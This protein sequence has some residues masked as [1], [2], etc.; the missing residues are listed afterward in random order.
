MVTPSFYAT[1]LALVVLEAT[2]SCDN[3][4]V[5]AICVK[6]LPPK[7][8]KHALHWGIAGAYIFRF[9][10]IGLGT[11]LV[12]LWWVKAIGGGYLLWMA[13]KF[14]YGKLFSADENEDGIPDNV[15]KG[16]FATIVTVEMMDIAFSADSVLAA[17]GVSESC[18]VLLIGGMLGILCMRF[19]AQLFV[20]LL[21]KVPELETAAYILIAVIGGK[22]IA[23]LETCKIDSLG[24]C[25]T[26]MGYHMS[27]WTFA[28]LLISI[29]GAT[30]IIN[31]LKKGKECPVPEKVVQP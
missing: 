29:F 15:Q 3:A 11:L 7:E 14:F 8:Q 19:A 5:L 6:H 20:K 25:V 13:G 9:I 31:Y 24:V 28:G 16:L 27:E 12:K 10:A 1:I 17:F 21:E 30:F 26:G 2:L 22:M 4:V 23:S 18:W